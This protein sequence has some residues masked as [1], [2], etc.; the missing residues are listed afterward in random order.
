LTDSAASDLPW[1]GHISIT[2]VVGFAS[3]AKS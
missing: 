1:R 3:L 2:K